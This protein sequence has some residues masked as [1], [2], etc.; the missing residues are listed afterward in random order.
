MK[1][2]TSRSTAET[3]A[4]AGS[5]TPPPE[6]APPLAAAPGR[7][8]TGPILGH[9]LT[10]TTTASIG[11]LAVFLVDTLSL[12]YVGLLNDP[13]LVAAVGYASTVIFVLISVA[14]GVSIAGAALVS[15]ALGAGDRDLA[16]RR[17][18]GFMLHMTLALAV[19][20][21]AV[22]VAAEHLVALVGASGRTAE[23]ATRYLQINAP[24][25]PLFGAG[26]GYSAVLRAVGDARR[27]MNV[28]LG[29][30]G[31][32]FVLDPI[33]ILVL[34]LGVD[35]A[36]MGAVAAR[37][38]LAYVG[39]RGAV[40][41]YRLVA[42]PTLSIF[43]SAAGPVWGIAAPAVATNV[44]SPVASGFV[45]KVLSQFGDQVVAAATVIDRLT[46]VAFCA[47]FALSGAIGPILGQNWGAHSFGRMREALNVAF[48]T[49]G[50][51]VL[52]VWGALALG[53]PLVAALFGLEGR[54]AELVVFFCRAAVVGWA[55]IG[56]LFVA[57]AAFN[58][59]GYPLMSTAFNWGRATIG[60]MPLA[61]LGANH[62]GPEG[63][64]VG[65]YAGA[66]LFGTAAAFAAYRVVGRLAGRARPEGVVAGVVPPR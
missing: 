18:S 57:N 17:A 25:L 4:A 13:V 40:R 36:A 35:G 63:V 31:V 47:L 52:V 20:A 51:Y 64:L 59:L 11:L 56:A 8:T 9:V 44:A 1:A 66:T 37:A 53:A 45:L 19:S 62:G 39:W 21:V 24:A 42:R 10:M 5:A 43:L 30:A 23:V 6:A 14:I 16:R 28:T 54:S 33:L 3:T 34:G 32:A 38:G 58:T 26:I 48:L 7:F 12:L 46:P 55:F 29:G 65:Q 27:A 60:T 49:S 41:H 15:R 22:F 61:L 2:E 50:L